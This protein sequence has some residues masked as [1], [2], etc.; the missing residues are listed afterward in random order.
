[1]NYLTDRK[2]LAPRQRELSATSKVLLIESLCVTPA[3]REASNKLGSDISLKLK[4]PMAESRMFEPS[5]DE[6]M[7]KDSPIQSLNILNESLTS[8][9]CEWMQ[10][11]N[12]VV[13]KETIEI[14]NGS[15]ATD[16]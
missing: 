11:M 14:H 8:R 5:I 16:R 15:K 13:A 1:M 12:Y 4:Q 2:G 3:H 6:P 9:L 7:S 10:S